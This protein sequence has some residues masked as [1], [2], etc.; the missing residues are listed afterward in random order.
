MK[1]SNIPMATMGNQS[2]NHAILTSVLSCED[3]PLFADIYTL[4]KIAQLNKRLY[5]QIINSDQVQIK[6]D[7]YLQKHYA[8]SIAD[9]EAYI[10]AQYGASVSGQNRLNYLQTLALLKAFRSNTASR[11][12]RRDTADRR[13][14]SLRNIRDKEVI[15]LGPTRTMRF[16]TLDPAGEIVDIYLPLIFRQLPH[17]CKVEMDK[18]NQYISACIIVFNNELFYSL[19]PRLVDVDFNGLFVIAGVAGN[20]AIQKYLWKNATARQRKTML[21]YDEYTAFF[22]ACTG[23]HQATAQWMWTLATPV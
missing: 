22:G 10:S 8:K 12:P 7:R 2:V 23:G 6:L 9:V 15:A 3:S 16:I 11:L 5:N 18:L 4:G 13:N 20:L 1:N 14:T 19:Y 21:E 17:L